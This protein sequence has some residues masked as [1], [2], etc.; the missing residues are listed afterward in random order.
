MLSKLRRL[1]LLFILV[2]GIS[3]L[4]LV[5]SYDHQKKMSQEIYAVLFHE[6]GRE[7]EA[8]AKLGV[9]LGSKG[10]FDEL[11]LALENARLAGKI[12]FY[13]LQNAGHTLWFGEKNGNLDRIEIPWEVNSEY[14]GNDTIA[15]RT[16]DI[17]QGFRL[18]LGLDVETESYVA[19][20]GDRIRRAMTQDFLFTFLIVLV[21][22]IWSLRDMM[23][24]VREVKRGKKGR[25]S[26][27]SA[28]SAE[29][30]LFM[31]GLT[32]YAQAVSDLE[33]ENI[34]LGRQVLPSLQKEIHSG[35]KPPYDFECTMVRTDINHFSTIFNT[36]NVT[37]F[38]ATINDFFDE[39]SR[40]VARYGGLV[41]EFVGDEVI[42]Y[43]KDDEHENSFAVALSAV[44]DI[45]EIA[46]KFN[47]KTQTTRGYPFTV[48]SSAAH[49]AVRFGPLVSG[50]TIAGSV[51]IET[52][53]I[54]GYI[55]EKD[56]NVVYFDGVHAPRVKGLVES[57]ERMQ[58]LMKGYQSEIAL[59]QYI[60]HLPLTDIL[61][62]LNEQSLGRLG[63]YRGDNEL[64]TILNALRSQAS[65]N[66]LETTLKAIRVL[67]EPYIASA[68]TKLSP[69]IRAWLTELNHEFTES[70]DESVGKI[71]S[72]V[73]K[74]Y[75]NLVPRE[76]FSNEDRTFLNQLMKNTD[77]RV[78]ANTVEVLAHFSSGPE[79]LQAKA[80]KELR[81]DLRIAA[82]SIV[83]EGRDELTAAVIKKLS[84]LLRS[85]KVNERASGLYA[86]GE[87]AAM[88]R[89]RDFAYYSAHVDF[90]NLIARI[91]LDAQH[92][93]TMVRR[94]ALTAARKAADEAVI[95]R[96]RLHVKDSG[97]ELLAE[98]L[99]RYL[100]KASPGSNY[101][102][103]AA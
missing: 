12:N 97:S 72:A 9:D 52:V 68:L 36:H 74:L 59:H 10:L 93:M 95:N 38:M 86:L 1:P 71:L 39:V 4:F 48:K 35:R 5:F 51:L 45:N 70:S 82:N 69:D 25:L 27:I 13:L 8:Y 46:E 88:H 66:P 60:A 24:M 96:I 31:K 84:G 80:R 7:L 3:V 29:S 91:D 90:Q 63:L 6:H 30:E 101:K 23:L 41:H 16:I 33:A 77:R 34:K 81:D 37:E 53:R 78:V 32:G 65:V 20:D 103:S 28:H 56:E 21:V 92:T 18:T 42:Y 44:R 14:Q 50:F 67:R 76:D 99:R 100:D 85:K 57:Q 43:F 79:T 87:L 49:G 94:Q 11:N 54:L 102:N 62:K 47:L 2:M 22:G 75:I 17:G 40:V 15:W 64:K 26:K 55:V 19:K 61:G 89:S 83:L 98:E 73:V 58:V